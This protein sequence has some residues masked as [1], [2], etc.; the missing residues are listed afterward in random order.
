[1]YR[2][3]SSFFVSGPLPA[4]LAWLG[5]SCALS[6]VMNRYPGTWD[7]RGGMA[8]NLVLF[9]FFGVIVQFSFFLFGCGFMLLDGDEMRKGQSPMRYHGG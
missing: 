7:G 1:M 8:N 6:P 4:I 3:V 9:C 5:L 2:G